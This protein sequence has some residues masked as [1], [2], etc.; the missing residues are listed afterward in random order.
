MFG[1]KIIERNAICTLDNGY[2]FR[3]VFQIKQSFL[4]GGGISQGVGAN[5]SEGFQRCPT[6]DGS[7]VDKGSLN[8]KLV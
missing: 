8:E 5:I 1:E 7:Q 2:K 4:S 3:A 6:I